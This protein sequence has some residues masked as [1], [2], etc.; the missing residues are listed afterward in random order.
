MWTCCAC[1]DAS[2][3]NHGIDQRDR[4]PD[5][6]SRSR[7]SRPSAGSD[8]YAR[9]VSVALVHHSVRHPMRSQRRTAPAARRRVSGRRPRHYDCV[10]RCKPRAICGNCRKRLAEEVKQRCRYETAC[11][12]SCSP[13]GPAT[14][15]ARPPRRWRP[16]ASARRSCSTR[17]RPGPGVITERDILRSVGR[18]QD[19]DVELVAAAPELEA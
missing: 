12:T 1:V 8:G 11:P 9:R 17:T 6:A 5:R 18:G 19:P 4:D 15:C 13:S 3:G 14:R 16:A 2:V 10:N 7:R